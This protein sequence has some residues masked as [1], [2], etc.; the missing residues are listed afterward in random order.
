MKKALLA[1]AAAAV[2]GIGAV[3]WFFQQEAAKTASDD[4]TVWEDAVADL[5]EEDREHP[6]PAGA[7]LFVGS[8]SIRLWRSLAE[9][10]APLPVIRHGFGGARMHDVLHYADRLVLRHGDV[11]AVVVF[12][13]TNDVNV[14]ETPEAALGAVPVIRDGFAELVDR[15]HAARPGLPVFWIDITPTR[16]SWE[17]RAAVD[18]ANAAVAEICAAREAVHCIETREAF[19]D[20]AG[21]PDASLFLF[22]GL[23]LNADGYARWTGLIKP[24]LAALAG[25]TRPAAP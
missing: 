3:A 9:D 4:P 8:S 22:D 23:H 7:F 12:V 5:E 21:E 15:I 11:R 2:L 14:A 20:A 13:G 24:R 19:L 17:K 10:M 1:L 18:A 6:P 16:F 25:A